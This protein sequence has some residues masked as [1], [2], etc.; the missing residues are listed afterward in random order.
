M[1]AK[2]WAFVFRV[3]LCLSFCYSDTVVLWYATGRPHRFGKAPVGI[4]HWT[5]YAGFTRAEAPC[6]DICDC[7]YAL[8]CSK[9]R[10]GCEGRYA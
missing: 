5:Y 10:E 8:L 9:G 3:E 1:C 4:N 7:S 6:P 2:V